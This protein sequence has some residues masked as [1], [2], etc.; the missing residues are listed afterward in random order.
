MLLVHDP[1]VE[2]V[3]HVITDTNR[4][5]AQIF[6]T[7]LAASLST[8]GL[9]G[10][11]VAIAPGSG[12]A[13]L[14]VPTL[15]I[16]PR[17]LRT[18]L[19]LRREMSDSSAVVAHG[20]HTLWAC[21]AAGQGLGVPLVYR[22]ISDPAY[23][24]S[25]A[26]RRLRVRLML[27]STAHVV[28]L[29][30]GGACYLH[31]AL[32][33]ARGKLTVIPNAVQT[34]RFRPPTASERSSARA[35]FGIPDSA[36]VLI[37]PAALQPEKHPEAA[38]S[39]LALLPEDTHLLMVGDG[40]L[41]NAILEMAARVAPGRVVMPGQIDD[42]VNAYWAADVAVLPSEG[43]GLPAALIEAGLCGLPAVASTSGGNESIVVDHRGGRVV[44]P[45][46]PIGLA[47]AVLDVMPQRGTLGKFAE[48]H[49]RGT[50]EI[51]TVAERWH[52]VLNDV[53][54]TQRRAG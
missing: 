54:V 15:G 35:R 18:L 30:P 32:G 6:A 14:S 31:E 16:A 11:V 4:R 23:W 38:V 52:A 26:T 37:Y 42:V 47:R 13:Q 40:P 19:S 44:P 39:A 2:R 8:R 49:C 24:M 28:A 3:L 20:S 10:D 21:A 51:D 25:T 41:R 5:G 45:A 53:R 48:R 34:E 36:N 29:W 1:S 12:G 33:V 22:N 17:N 27:R 43:E 9:P 46:D 50:F 7:D